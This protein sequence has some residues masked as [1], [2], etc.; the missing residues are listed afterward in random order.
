[1]LSAISPPPA[2]MAPTISG[3]V[4][5]NPA[6]LKP[7]PEN[8][9]K[10]SA[11]QKAKLGAAIR[12]FG[13][14]S[15][16]VT[17]EN[18]F[19]LSGHCRVEVAIEMGLLTIPVRVISGLT[20]AEKLAFVL[21]DNKLGDMSIWDDAK[22]KATLEILIREEFEIETT[23]FSTAEVDLI[24]DDNKA[25]PS[26]DSGDLLPTDIREEVVTRAGDLWILGQH[27][28]LCGNSLDK[29]SYQRVMAEGV[30]Q[31]VIS[32]APF[33]VPVSGHV[34]GSGKTQHKE[35]AMASGEMSQAE[36]TQFLNNA[37]THT[38]HFSMDG[39]I[40]YYFMDWRHMREL[41]DAAEPLFGSLRQLCVWAKDNGGM[42]TFYRSQHE[43]VFVFKKGDA[44]HINN[45]E[46]GQHGRY[47]TNVWQYPGVNT[48]T[49]KGHEL[50]AL[51]PTVKNVS[52]IA[53]AIR[54]CSHRKGLILDP[55]AGSGTLLVAAERT[56]RY[57]RAI[58]IDPH[59]VDVGVLR[60]QRIIGKEAILEATGQTWSQ[61][62][63]ERLAVS[64]G[65]P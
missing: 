28:L 14:T 57:A 37:F 42:G 13:F 9:R 41:L 45:F 16:V 11:K 17:D 15:I 43:L 48:F 22:L 2:T 63:T 18:S 64:G 65:Q 55:F 53:D 12:K 39:A 24:F 8:P 59:Y 33:N 56:G 27:R 54:D 25:S 44:P 10:H 36:F 46:L 1:M 29:D 58:E 26:A 60:W 23:G 30:A 61:V 52:L 21:A 4:D 31:M 62:R 38:H 6:D 34:C 50:L 5:Q 40:H 7:W 32:D 35:F 47:R 19:I 20:E 49:G 51:H 3:I